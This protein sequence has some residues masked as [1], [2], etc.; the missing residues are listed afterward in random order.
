MPIT[1]ADMAKYPFLP[2]AREHISKIEIDFDTLAAW[3]EAR[4]QAKTR[5]RSC[6]D[7]A[8]RFSLKPS[9]T[10]DVQIAS[11]P[12]AI[13]YLAR[14]G[15][16]KLKERFALFEAQI[17]NQYLQLER[18]EEIII[19]IA[20]AFKWKGSFEDT[21]NI[22]IEFN[23]FAEN[24]S[25]GRLTHDLKWK[26]VNRNVEKGFVTIT[27]NELSRLLQEEVQN[28]IKRLT[29]QKLS[30]LPEELEK[31][32]EEIK[33][34]FDDARPQLEEFDQILR[35]Q[36]S[37]YPPCISGFMKR[38]ASGQHLSHAERFTLVTY[39]VH[40]GVSIESIV[41]LFS[42]VPDFNLTKTKYQVENLAGMTGGRTES[43]TTYNCDTLR[44]HGVCSGAMDIVC[45]R[46]RNPLTYHVMKQKIDDNT[47]RKQRL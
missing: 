20:K 21:S 42:N 36:E 1:E 4:L 8:I 14:V 11:F 5:I 13:L 32:V 24:V 18:R 26:L 10:F 43:Y 38:A 28:H 39:L 45:R 44:T 29:N 34:A 17:I 15:D 19:E 47:K 6:F 2:Q 9:K 46:I 30:T 40:Q 31:D 7:I 33:K 25:R 23:K 41:T 3:P 12:L 37:E 16:L 22:S 35:A 27:P